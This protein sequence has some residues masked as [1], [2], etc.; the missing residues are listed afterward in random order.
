MALIL[1]LVSMICVVQKCIIDP[2]EDKPVISP[3]LKKLEAYS[4]RTLHFNL[5]GFP[6]LNIFP[7]AGFC[8]IMMVLRHLSLL[9]KQMVS[10][11][12]F[13]CDGT[14]HFSTAHKTSRFMG[15]WLLCFIVMVLDIFPCSWNKCFIVMVLDIFPRLIK[16]VALLTLLHIFHLVVHGFWLLCFIVMVLDIS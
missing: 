12:L 7:S 4:S 6:R 3:L 2:A 13:H 16:E 9:M 8:F 10:Q 1:F 14:R 5:Q 15:F 11:T